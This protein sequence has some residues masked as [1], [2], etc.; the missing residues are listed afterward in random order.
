MNQM[1]ALQRRF[2]S[3]FSYI[4]AMSALTDFLLELTDHELAA[5][6]HFRYEQ[7]MQGSKDKILKE[8]ENRSIHVGSIPDYLERNDS[9]KHKIIENDL[10]PR[11][12]S[13]K[14][15]TS[16]EVETITYSYASVDLDVDYKTCLVCLFS[17][18]KEGN[19]SSSFGFVTGLGFISRLMNRKR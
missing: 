1:R 5:F 7:F 6:Y 8:L 14:F 17:E 15:Y 2:I 12:M 19:V 13:S 3:P 16:H 18:E 4:D 10:C 9:D 11:C